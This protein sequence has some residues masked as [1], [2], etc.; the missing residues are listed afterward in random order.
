M[1]ATKRIAGA[2]SLV[3]KISDTELAAR[4]GVSRQSVAN[5]R[6]DKGIAAV[7]GK[8]LS[9]AD[10][11]RI[12]P[13]VVMQ[14]FD[15]L[16]KVPD[17]DI[18]GKAGVSTNSVQALRTKWG[19]A[20]HKAAKSEKKTDGPPAVRKS[21]VGVYLDMLGQV[22]D[23]EIAAMAGVKVSSVAAY[24]RRHGIPTFDSPATA[25]PEP[26]TEGSPSARRKAGRRSKLDP[27][28]DLL[29]TVPDREVAAKAGV[30]TSAVAVYR[31][32]WGLPAFK[33]TSATPDVAP[34]PAKKKAASASAAPAPAKKKKVASAPVAPAPA[35]KKTKKK[36]AAPV[37]PAPAAAA[38]M[39][40][41]EVLG[42]D[43]PLFVVAATLSAAAAAAEAAG[44]GEGI[45][46]RG[47]L[48]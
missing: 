24:R 20:A 14:F 42:V 32:R 29:G 34:A 30:S 19:I 17:G 48:L 35:Q 4:L 12:R 23:S 21:K 2:H 43:S 37:A 9:K 3:G 44:H 31:R 46:R 1:G 41:W 39:V 40:V 25:T 33:K 38:P 26:V 6:R 13:S 45:R 8:R 28:A 7:K 36:V 18:A 5:Y 15:M 16:G 22:P 27:Y 10:L 11:A 47:S